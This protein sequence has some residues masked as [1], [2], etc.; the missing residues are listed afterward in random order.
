MNIF[1][2]TS[3]RGDLTQES[4]VIRDSF[5]KLAGVKSEP[6]KIDPL[7]IPK[8]KPIVLFDSEKT[9]S[10]GGLPEMTQSTEPKFVSLSDADGVA[11]ISSKLE[12][13]SK[14]YPHD[15]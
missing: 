2:N 6:L 13:L 15:I 14:I 7:D 9:L 4:F 12:F 1:T 11:E 3:N 5:K 10:F 8:S